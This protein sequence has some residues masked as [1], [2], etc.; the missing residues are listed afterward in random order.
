MGYKNR[1][2]KERRVISKHK[3]T[4]I[5]KNNLS[6]AGIAYRTIKGATQTSSVAVKIGDIIY[7]W[8]TKERNEGLKED[9]CIRYKVDEVELDFIAFS[10]YNSET[11]AFFSLLKMCREYEYGE[12]F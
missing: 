2:H 5:Y 11:M 9:I 12:V 1:D 4:R 8:F 7:A 3:F 6:K 10:P